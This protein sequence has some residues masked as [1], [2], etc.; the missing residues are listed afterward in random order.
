M[1][2][3]R[4]F[5]TSYCIFIIIV[6]SGCSS[7]KTESSKGIVFS[8]EDEEITIQMVIREIN[9]S[10]ALMDEELLNIKR[11]IDNP[12][13]IMDFVNL[14][15]ARDMLIIEELHRNLKYRKWSRGGKKKFLLSFT[16]PFKIMENPEG[17]PGIL[18]NMRQEAYEEFLYLVQHSLLLQE[19]PWMVRSRFDEKS[20]FAYWYILYILRNIDPLWIDIAILPGMLKLI[21]LD[22]ITP[23][24]YL[25]LKNPQ[26][27]N[28]MDDEIAACGYPWT[29]LFHLIRINKELLNL[30]DQLFDNREVK[31]GDLLEGVFL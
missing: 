12:E 28:S 27:L 30:V 31:T 7:L 2:I 13:W 23:V 5:I 1:H 15:A 14:T 10:I 29:N 3:I 16:D 18:D 22:E 24:T 9:A 20:E 26:S 21:P 17:H 6:L 19:Y 11:D 25:W 8:L 4:Y